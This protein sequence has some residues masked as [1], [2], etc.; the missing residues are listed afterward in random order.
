MHEITIQTLLEGV[1]IRTLVREN[2]YEF[3]ALIEHDREHLNQFGE[4]IADEFPDMSAVLRSFD[5]IGLTHYQHRFRFGIWNAEV[6]VGCIQLITSD[7]SNGCS[8]GY[9]IGS[10]HTRRGFA[11]CALYALTEYALHRYSFCEALVHHDNVGS[12]E[13]L[14][15]ARYTRSIRRNQGQMLLYEKYSS[16]DFNIGLLPQP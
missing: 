2:A 7:T 6:L 12:R 8:V 15:R 10:Q 4:H 3:L 14:R 13:V 9:W 5:G 11:L 1:E 16:N